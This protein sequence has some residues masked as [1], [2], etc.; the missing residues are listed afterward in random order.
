MLSMLPRCK[1]TFYQAHMDTHN[2]PHTDT[3]TLINPEAPL[4][5]YYSSSGVEKEFGKNCDQRIM[6][7]LTMV[8]EDDETQ[9]IESAVEAIERHEDL[10]LN[11]AEDLNEA[12]VQE[13]EVDNLSSKD[14]QDSGYSVLEISFYELNAVTFFA[15][16]VASRGFLK[17]QCESCREDMMKSP[18][19][20]SKD[21]EYYIRLREYKNL[22]GDA[23]EVEKLTRP[24]DQL[25]YIVYEQLRS[26]HSSWEK[27]WAS[28]HLLD[29]LTEEAENHT[30]QHF[31]E[32]FRVDGPCNAHRLNSLRFMLRVKVYAK[33]RERN[34]QRKAANIHMKKKGRKVN[35]VMNI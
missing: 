24:R 23:P 35:N 31:P 11:E 18:M 30:K 6:D 27:Y 9:E 17:S 15:G 29:H 3:L 14:K 8:E 4:Y 2:L 26:F 5:I 13:V 1:N 34:G 19:E 16:Y 32:W 25:S 28:E 7:D 20:E 12:D 21:N 10:I 33:I 22:D